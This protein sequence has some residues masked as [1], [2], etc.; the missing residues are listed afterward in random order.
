MSGSNRHNQKVQG[1]PGDWGTGG[2]AVREDAKV[3]KLSYRMEVVNGIIRRSIRG[4]V[5]FSVSWL[6]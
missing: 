4:W 3:A 6:L 1:V 2:S 5:I